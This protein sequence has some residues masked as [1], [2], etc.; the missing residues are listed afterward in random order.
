MDIHEGHSDYINCDGCGVAFEK[1]PGN[2]RRNCSR[3]CGF[4]SM[5]AKNKTKK[6]K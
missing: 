6:K 1:T 5:A 4:E 3:A 2:P